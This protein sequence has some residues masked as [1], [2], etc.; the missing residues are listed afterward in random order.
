MKKEEEKQMQQPSSKPNYHYRNQQQQ[1][2]QRPVSSQAKKPVNDQKA[3]QQVLSNQ[4]QIV[5]NQG[6]KIIQHNPN[7]RPQDN[8]AAPE[9]KNNNPSSANKKPDPHANLNRNK[10][11][12]KSLADQQSQSNQ[13]QQQQQHRIDDS[14]REVPVKKPP[15]DPKAKPQII[16]TKDVVDVAVGVFSNPNSVQNRNRKE[17]DFKDGPGKRVDSLEKNYESPKRPNIKNDKKS[18]PQTARDPK[19]GGQLKNEDPNLKKK[20]EGVP[21]KDIQPQPTQLDAQN[22]KV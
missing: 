5:E 19:N 22:K 9:S 11:E 10:W 17:T 2:S 12:K 3:H 13:K 4:A 21:K 8:K 7:A 6:P 15:V 14:Q 18:D 16:E 20:L 1:P